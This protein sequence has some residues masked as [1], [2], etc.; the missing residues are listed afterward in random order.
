MQLL[1]RMFSAIVTIKALKG[2]VLE[3]HFKDHVLLNI[4]FS[5]VLGMAEK[6]VQDGFLVSQLI[7]AHEFVK[8]M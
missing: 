3:A 2:C 8:Y 6:R 5:D 7:K 1:N 4:I